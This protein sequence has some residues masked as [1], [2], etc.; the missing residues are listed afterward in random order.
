MVRIEI[1]FGVGE[2]KHRE[3]I[4]D[5]ELK[6]HEISLEAARTFGGYTLI[7]GSGGWYNGKDLITENSMTL[8]LVTE[9]RLGEVFE[10]ARSLRNFVRETLDQAAVVLTIEDVNVVEVK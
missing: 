5:L 2:N 6:L 10:D 3:P 4:K 1:T 9:R 8:R 7:P